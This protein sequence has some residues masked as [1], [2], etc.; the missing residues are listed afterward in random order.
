MSDKSGPYPDCWKRGCEFKGFYKE[1]AQLAPPP[2]PR[3]YLLANPIK[4][5]HKGKG[6]VSFDTGFGQP[7]SHIKKKE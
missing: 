6:L 4:D 1:G 2:H 5:D 3:A 7:D